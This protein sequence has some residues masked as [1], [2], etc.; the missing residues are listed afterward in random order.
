MSLA[1]SGRDRRRDRRIPHRRPNVTLPVGRADV[2]LLVDAQALVG[3]AKA[4]CQI[5]SATSRLDGLAEYIG[6]LATALRRR[7]EAR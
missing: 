3:R 4:K 6:Q 2:D 1:L 7:H 5:P